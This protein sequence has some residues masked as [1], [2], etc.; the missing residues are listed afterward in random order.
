IVLTTPSGQT[1]TEA[2]I[3]AAPDMAIVEP[4]SDMTRRVVVVSQPGAGVWN[5]TVD[6]DIGTGQI[7]FF[8]VSDNNT[9]SGEITQLAGGGFG[10]PVSISY[11]ASDSDNDAAVSLFY[12]SDASGLDGILI[13]SGITQADGVGMS[14]W[15]TTGVPDG[16]Y[17]V[18]LMIDDGINAPVIAY[19]QQ[20]VSV[21]H[22]RIDGQVFHD[23][24]ANAVMDEGESPVADIAVFVDANGNATLDD[25]ESFAITAADGRYRL[26]ELPQGTHTIAMITPAGFIQSAPADAAAQPI[27]LAADGQID[28]VNFG[29]RI[30]PASVSGVVW[31]D[32][33]RDGFRDASEAV[34][35]GVTIRLIDESS[36]IH[37][38][39]AV[40]PQDGRFEFAGV[41]PG[42]YIL[43]VVTQT[44]DQITLQDRPGSDAHDS[45]LDPVTTR[46]RIELVTGASLTSIDVGLF[47]RWNHFANPFDVDANGFVRLLDALVVINFLGRSQANQPSGEALP[48]DGTFPDVNGN[49][50]V[51]PLDALLVI[52]HVAIEQE[53]KMLPANLIATSSLFPG[54]WQTEGTR[55]DQEWRR[56]TD[57]EMPPVDTDVKA[58]STSA[59]QTTESSFRF[60]DWPSENQQTAR[61]IDEEAPLD[62]LLTRL[63]QDLRQA[64]LDGPPKE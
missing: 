58:N 38:A 52:N 64:A 54:P 41:V 49:G 31:Q 55:S 16:E 30:E 43:E 44:I 25:D 34:R 11:N 7:E 63:A 6:S 28:D 15:D 29:I 10:Q 12:D 26:A 27:E 61:D 14:T 23:A 51:S 17:F 19:S 59:S 32:L 40:T 33:N 3:I 13:D 56:T 39:Q 4:L 1:L 45:N 60:E 20:S 2:D 57:L 50:T 46:R 21:T 48:D 35:K 18:Y 47:S 5:L 53:N 37:V 36:G 24:N 22:R 9:P 42:T 62:E 8:V